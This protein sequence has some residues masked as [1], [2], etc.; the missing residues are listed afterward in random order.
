VGVDF[1]RDVLIP[2]GSE[3]LEALLQ[4]D[5]R[6]VMIHTLSDADQPGIPPPRV[7][8]GSGQTGLADQL[9]DADDLVRRA[10][11]YADDED[12]NTHLSLALQLALRWLRVADRGMGADPDRPEWIRLGDTTLPRMPSDMGGY[13][14]VDAHGYQILVDYDGQAPLRSVSVSDV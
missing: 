14:D 5:P 12:G 2:P 8:R 10:L 3:Q 9:L 6:L 1:F 4:S 7:L 11:L 13:S